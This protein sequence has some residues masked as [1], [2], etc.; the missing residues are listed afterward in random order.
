MTFVRL[1]DGGVPHHVRVTGSGP[2]CVLSAGLGLAWFDW[3]PVVELLAPWRTVVRFD[4]PGAGLSGHARVPPTLAGEAERIAR[5]LD[6]V[7]LPGPATV[8]GHSL[9][10]FHC[11]AFAR[12]FPAR[13]SGLVLA[14]S[15]VE[16][17]PGVRVPR[18][19]R[20]GAARMCGAVLGGAGVPRALGPVLRRAAVRGDAV[21]AD[22]VRRV[23]GASRVLRGS[24]LEYA[25][26]GDLAAELAALRREL[27]LREGLPV[28]VLAAYSRGTTTW[29]TRQRNL[30]ASLEATFRV[31][32]PS[33]HLVMRDAPRALA[34]AILGTA[35]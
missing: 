3:D 11:E 25:T 26:Y 16:E 19:V 13:T 6:A 32:S 7:G 31:A 8:V 4:R 21:R 10:G 34:E 30:A 29:L 18:G 14:D 23:Y 15:S 9:A 28:T 17:R 27:P 5:V 22:A 20:V 2:V 33:G 12:L 35:R 24:L 1:G